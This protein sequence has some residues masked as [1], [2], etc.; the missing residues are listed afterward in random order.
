MIT[1]FPSD[2]QET[3][4]RVICIPMMEKTMESDMETGILWGFIGITRVLGCC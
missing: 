1:K 3:G 4:F 2:Q